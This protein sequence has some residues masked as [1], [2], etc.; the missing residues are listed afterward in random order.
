MRIARLSADARRVNDTEP[1]REQS[2][3]E[4]S[5]AAGRQACGK[6][7]IPLVICKKFAETPARPC[8]F[9]RVIWG[10]SQVRATACEFLTE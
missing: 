1:K 4:W 2:R 9:Y 7:P 10:D 6:S 3:I 5:T 8:K